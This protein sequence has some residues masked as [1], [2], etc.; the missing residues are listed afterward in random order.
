MKKISL[1]LVILILLTCFSGCAEK[2][3]PE[4][5]PDDFSFSLIFGV[6]GTSSYDS[7][8]GKL[9]KT[10]DATH[11]EDYV[12][13][14]RLSDDTLDYVYGLLLDLDIDDYPAEY[15]PDR[16]TACT[17]SSELTLTVRAGGKT[18]TVKVEDM[19]ASKI[20]LIGKAGRYIETYKYIRELLTASAEWKSLPEYE[21]FYD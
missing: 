12:T 17:P 11:P 7:R 19:A 5:R 8:T 4:E 2:T 14:L 15:D 21:F 6:Y 9:V 20:A 3:L 1:V 16:H 18:K 10:T 13:Y